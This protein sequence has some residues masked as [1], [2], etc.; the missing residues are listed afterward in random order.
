VDPAAGSD[1]ERTGP[2][3]A[4]GPDLWAD[5]GPAGEPPTRTVTRD[6]VEIVRTT[7]SFHP[8]ELDAVCARADER[9]G[10]VLSSGMEY[11]GRYSRWHLAY[12]NPCIE[13]VARGRRIGARA[14]NARGEVLLPVFRAALQRAGTL[15]GEAGGDP[16][17][18][19]G[20]GGRRVEVTIPE[21]AGLLAEEDRSRRPTVFSALREIIAAFAGSDSHLG[22]Y[23]AFGYD[24]AFQF[25]P[26]RLRHERPASQRD[27]VLHL[28]DE[29]YVLDR[30]RETATRYRYEF[31][32]NGVSTQGLARETEPA[33][34]G[35]RPV[36]A[37][38]PPGFQARPVAGS[39]ARVVEQARERF[40]RGDLF[41]VVPSQPFRAPC[42]SAAAFY[43]LLRQRNP[44]P[45]EFFF[46]LG[47]GESL[48]G[49]SPE[50]YVRVTGDRVETCP[51]SGTIRRGAD[52]LEDAA[53]IRTLLNSAKEESELTMC[54]DVD[55]N[56]KSRVCVPGSVKVI[57]RRQIEMYSRLMHTVDH[58]EGRLRPGLDA[59]DA[60]LT[61]MWAV[62]VT[63]APKT[64]A[65]QFIE[66]HE[67]AP[68][69]WYGGAVG[70]MGF[71]GSMNTGLTLRTAHISDGIATVRAGAT[72]LFD[73][74]PAAE[75]AETELKAR[76]LLE[77]LA[78]AGTSPEPAAGPPPGRP[79]RPGPAAPAAPPGEGVRVLLVDHQDSFVHTLAAY[80][81]EQGAEVTTLRAGLP[82]SALDEFRPGLV[83]L[84]PGPGRPSDFG[85]DGLLAELDARGLPAFGVCLGLQAMVEHA[86]GELAL[87]PQPVHG[88]PGTIRQ[89]CQRPGGLLSGLPTE[90]TAA[91]YHSLYAVPPQVKAGFEVT[92]VTADGAVMAIEN[93]AAG[94]WAVQFHPESILTAAGDAGYQVIANVL[95]LAR[96]AAAATAG[97]RR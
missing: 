12:V 33:G 18:R 15:S 31:T 97:S 57:G 70:A 85:C 84:S 69:R 92:A 4:T 76:A 77:T 65:M 7:G 47:E 88:K 17:D 62:T 74:D 9:R 61:H 5:P 20:R 41:E 72:L 66:D 3:A 52:P 16:D 26:V 2:A 73:S 27:L 21:P 60:F 55:R 19:D 43:Q 25:E 24:L 8:A 82:A 14:L 58:I 46:N 50:M 86:G 93:P 78:A 56:D 80:F 28:P 42:T 75:E 68:R 79:V 22:L 39:Y 34:C 48:V 96:T 95:R 94:R 54:T 11:P 83:V 90:F 23:G 45:F 37:A 64:W 1:V 36:S 91:R 13:V 71:D 10:G 32:V 44:A 6:G 81:R 63:G 30:K 87:L 38:A 51:I 35:S 53:N 40:A 49:A 67:Q 29:L 89:T 59:L